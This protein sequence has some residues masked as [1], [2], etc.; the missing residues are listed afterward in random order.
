MLKKISSLFIILIILV[1]KT[2]AQVKLITLDPG[3]FHAALVQ[4]TSL[5]GVDDKVK[6]YAPKG[7]DLDQHLAKI[8]AYN[9]RADNPTKWVEDIYIGD[10]FFERMIR[11]KP[12]DVVIMAGNNA[13]KTAYIYRTVESG[14]NV[15]ADKPMCID[16]EGFNLLRKAFK[17]A[18]KNNVLLYDIM[19]ERS[20]I[21]TILQ[22]EISLIP[23][24]FGTLKKGTL[25]DPSV[26]K[27]SIHHLYKN[28]S[29]SPLIRP[30]WFMDTRQQ[31]E[32]IVDVTT[33]LVDL[34]QWAA[35]PG[36]SL[37]SSDS[38]VISAKRW[39]TK[40]T[41]DQFKTITGAAQFPN[42]LQND[43]DGNGVL[44]TYANG[45]IDFLL[46]NVHARVKVL[47]N[48][49]AKTGGDTHYSI[50]KGTKAN[51]EIRQ[52]AAENFIPELYIQPIGIS[53][54]ALKYSF[55]KIKQKYPSVTI[56]KKGNEWLVNIPNQLRTGHEAHFGEVM[57]RYLGYLKQN[58]LPEWE[59][60]GMLS[61]YKITTEGLKMAKK[62]P[63]GLAKSK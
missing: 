60:P 39:P 50:M 21:N 63:S 6:V 52:G 55:E 61:K 57:E 16:A 1:F 14:M 46:K 10:D 12:G 4:K 41:L 25:E 5:D 2:N 30:E 26:I 53:D 56:S 48:F 36:V 9:Q 15:L 38:K 43:I 37:K 49:E 17:V 22:K 24:I 51:L 13:K 31:G 19:T 58:K 59:V 47:W 27:E 29:G 32:G 44:N 8:N 54:A 3:H 23:E 34:V 20:E 42:F 40:M 11:E 28:V 35:F 33:H 62:L 18:K 7:K 45:Q